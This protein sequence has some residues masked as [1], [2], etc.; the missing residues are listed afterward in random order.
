MKNYKKDEFETNLNDIT[1]EQQLKL[2]KNITPEDVIKLNKITDGKN[3]FCIS[4]MYVL[5]CFIIELHK[6]YL[7]SPEANTYDI[8][9]T[10]FKI[11]DM[12]TGTILFEIGKPSVYDNLD[13][14]EKEEDIDSNCG[15]LVR[16]HFTSQFLKLKTVGAT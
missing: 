8:E 13:E 1:Y 12:D 14:I 6:G 9:F 4:F 10:R 16:Y 7:C 3:K 2:K 11:R 5:I 15:R